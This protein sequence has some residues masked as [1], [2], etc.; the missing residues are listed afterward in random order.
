MVGPSSASPD[1]AAA[2]GGAVSLAYPIASI[3]R[4]DH[5]S[6]DVVFD[7]PVRAELIAEMAR[8]RSA[9]TIRA[10]AEQVTS[11][12]PVYGRRAQG[13]L[14]KKVAAAVRRAATADPERLRFQPATGSTEARIIIIRSPEQFD[15]RGRTQGYQAVFAG[16]NRRRPTP[17][18]PEQLDLF[19]VLDDAELAASEEVYESGSDSS[20]NVA[21]RQETGDV[22][23]PT[24]LR[25]RQ[26]REQ[27]A[28]KE[29]SRDD[30]KG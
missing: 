20:D 18:V 1:L 28:T 25:Q 10:L 19:S 12:F 16:R 30:D 8:G 9:V 23:V 26:D 24:A 4:F 13:Q 17:Q 29:A 21:I 3:I 14:I 27:T 2:L 7:E 11:H 6:P 15:R 5:Q 22:D